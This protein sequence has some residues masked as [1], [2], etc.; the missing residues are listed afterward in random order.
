MQDEEDV[1]DSPKVGLRRNGGLCPSNWNV[2]MNKI[3]A[4]LR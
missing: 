4:G 1:E 3:A 2:G